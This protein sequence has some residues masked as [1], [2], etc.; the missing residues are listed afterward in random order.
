MNARILNVWALLMIFL[1]AI[2][3]ATTNIAMY[4][5]AY[6]MN[7]VAIYFM[8]RVGVGWALFGVGSGWNGAVIAVMWFVGK[9]RVVRE[10]HLKLTDKRFRNLLI[11]VYFMMFAMFA[12]RMLVAANN[13]YQW[14]L[15]LE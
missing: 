4:L 11:F 5:G 7:P 9:Y 10:K 15:L 2:D 12:G 14:S 3:I 6:E 13:F 1:T 8:R